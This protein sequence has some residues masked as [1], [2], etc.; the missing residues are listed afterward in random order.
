MPVVEHAPAKINLGLHV[1]RER[2]D[3]YHA[4]ETVLHRIGWY[5]TI[6]VERAPSVRMTCTDP[7]LPTNEENL[8]VQAALRLAEVLNIEQ[9]AAIHLEKRIPYGSGLGGGS[10]DAAATLRALTRLWDVEGA[11][12][13]LHT[14]AQGLGADVPFFLQDAPSAYATGIGDEL[15]VLQGTTGPY[16]IPFSLLVV[17]PSVQIS[18]PDAYDYVTPTD[19][20]RPDLS[21]VVTSN[22]L[23]RWQRSLMNDFDRP[24]RASYSDVAHI[25]RWL[26]EHG[27]DYV[28]LSG[29]GSAVYGVF[30]SA[31]RAQRAYEDGVDRWPEL[32]VLVGEDGEPTDES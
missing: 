7:T 16:Q 21:S 4:V 9:S 14:I 12:D 24:I 27:A 28:S 1:L 3:G 18:T 10:S 11:A 15:T 13:T 8:C 22:D 20:P 19:H 30:D 5:D 17:V 2:S 31:D 29:S 25:H 6:T 32:R 26:A 23:G